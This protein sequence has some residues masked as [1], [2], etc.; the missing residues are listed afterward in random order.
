MRAD[1]VRTAKAPG[2]LSPTTH[3]VA[4]DGPA[5]DPWRAFGYITAGVALYGAIGFALDWWLGTR[6]LV[7]IGIIAGAGF[8][9]YQTWARLQQAERDQRGRASTTPSIMTST[10][11]ETDQEDQ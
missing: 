11:N 3:E 5:Q 9:V 2:A 8:G 4:G 1:S 7:A 6:F 10:T